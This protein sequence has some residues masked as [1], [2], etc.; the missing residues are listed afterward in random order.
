MTID[1]NN[2]PLP[3]ISIVTPSLNQGRFL[4]QCIQ[5]VLSQD[6]DQIELIVIDGGSTD[7]SLDIIHRY[8]DYLAYWV[9]EPDEGQSDAINKGFRHARGDLVAWLNADDYYLENC[10]KTI[11]Q[12]YQQ[13]PEASFIFGDGVR[14]DE[15]GRQKSA[16]WEGQEPFFD[17]TALIYGLNY[18][19]QPASFINHRCLREVNYLDPNLHFGM[20]TDLW[21]RLSAVAE[22]IAVPA[23]L[24]ASREYADTKTSSGSFA[25]IEELR[26]IAEKYSDLPLTPGV[27]C[28]FLDTL[29]GLVA[30]RPDYFPESYRQDLL[31]FWGKSAALMEQFHAQPNGLP[32]KNWSSELKASSGFSSA[33]QP[34]SNFRSLLRRLHRIFTEKLK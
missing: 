2:A 16:Y 26:R 27:L 3:L 11:A 14:V 30:A 21:I 25:R 13:H 31:E 7:H 29:H 22:P 10:F 33:D 8:S 12:A 5:S 17:R 34:G 6:Y 24:A 15:Q 18:I 28:Y 4:E 1:S 19:L 32:L 9:S 20:D 23:A